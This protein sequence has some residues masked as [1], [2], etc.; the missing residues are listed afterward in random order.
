M[1]KD[2]FKKYVVE[3]E[4]KQQKNQT[5]N[6]VLFI[7]PIDGGPLT[8]INPIFQHLHSLYKVFETHGK[9]WNYATELA[10]NLEVGI[11]GLVVCTW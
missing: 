10:G 11:Q 5:T 4:N 1:A 7:F 6:D 8:F 9:K 3:K 2:V